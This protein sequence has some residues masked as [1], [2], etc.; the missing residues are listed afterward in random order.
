MILL[1]DEEIQEATQVTMILPNGE[2][3]P[4]Q[5]YLTGRQQVAKAQLKKVV[6]KITVGVKCQATDGSFKQCLWMD[7]SYWQALL[8]EIK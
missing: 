1:T 6:D 2:I 3:N 4:D 7:D 5:G 8:E